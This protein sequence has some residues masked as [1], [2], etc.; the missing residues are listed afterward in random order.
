MNVTYRCWSCKKEYK[1]EEFKYKNGTK[2]DCG[3]YIVSLSGKVSVKV[4]DSDNS[5][6]IKELPSTKLELKVFKMNDIDTVISHLTKE[7]TN[8]WYKKECCIGDDE[9]PLEYV[10]ELD[11]KQGYWSESGSIIEITDCVNSLKDGEELKIKKLSGYL[12]I[13]STFQEEIESLNEQNY[14]E[15]FVVCSTEW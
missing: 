3:G 13:W 14:T 10:E 9:Q 2:C 7:D 15:P 5:E 4:C 12:F 8:E 1:A 11:L 6:N